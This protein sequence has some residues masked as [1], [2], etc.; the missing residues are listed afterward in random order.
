MKLF[1]RGRAAEEDIYRRLSFDQENFDIAE[2]IAQARQEIEDAYNNFQNACD[3][4]L[5]DCY[6]YRGNAAWK[7]YCFLLRQAKA[8]HS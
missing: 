2:E 4:D 6:I 3:P 5:I 8:I 1:Q 7:R